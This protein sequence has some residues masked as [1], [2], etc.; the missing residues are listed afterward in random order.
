MELRLSLHDGG[1]FGHVCRLGVA[2]WNRGYL[3]ELPFFCVARSLSNLS[4]TPSCIEAL[5]N[6]S[7]FHDIGPNGS[8]PHSFVTSSSSS[9]DSPPLAPSSLVSDSSDCSEAS[10]VSASGDGLKKRRK[11]RRRRSFKRPHS[12][13]ECNN[14]QSSSPSA[15]YCEEWIFSSK[16]GD[17]NDSVNESFIHENCAK[18][19]EAA[20]A[21]S[22]SMHLS[23]VELQVN[24]SWL[25]EWRKIL[26]ITSKQDTVTKQFL[27]NR[28]FRREN[29][30]VKGLLSLPSIEEK[31]CDQS[32]TNHSLS[33]TSSSL[34]L[35]HV[36]D[37]SRASGSL[38]VAQVLKPTNSEVC[39]KLSND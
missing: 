12:N 5:Q 13:G 15:A 35:S 36:T 24:K 22:N 27:M 18:I 37:V 26:D 2:K 9:A 29:S 20:D 30:L 8:I 4:P 11:F 10:P 21:G 25:D 33:S 6:E 28:A 31:E 39:A 19:S 3:P 7:Q 14:R 34:T 38:A 16:S 32:E 1:G 17:E 23:E